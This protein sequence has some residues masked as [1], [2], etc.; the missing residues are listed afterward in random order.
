MEVMQRTK[1]FDTLELKLQVV[2]SQSP[3]LT[4]VMGIKL[5]ASA[6]A[7]CAPPLLSSLFSPELQF[8]NLR[9]QSAQQLPE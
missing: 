2:V 6:R 7:V 5:R 8:L 9:N 1:V 3:Q 4:W